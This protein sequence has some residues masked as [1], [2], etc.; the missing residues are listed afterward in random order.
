MNTSVSFLS[1]GGTP[2][3]L[4][5]SFLVLAAL[6][7]FA[8]KGAI[9]DDSLVV[10]LIL[11]SVLVHELCH[12]L[13]A[14]LFG[15][16][17]VDVV[18]Y[19]MGGV[20]KLDKKPTA[21]HEICIGLAGPACN[22]A[23]AG[24]LL[25]FQ[26]INGPNAVIAELL[27]AN[28]WIGAFNLLPAFPLDGGRVFRAALSFGFT[29]R[30]NSR[31]GIFVGRSVAAMIGLYGIWGQQWALPFVAFFIYTSAQKEFYSQKSSILMKGANV[32]E[33]MMRNFVTLQHGTS[34][35]EAA[36]L[37]LDSPQQDFPVM[38][39]TQVVG[40]LS[41]DELVDA[42]ANQGPQS[43]VA[44][45]M[46]RDFLRL[47]PVASIEESIRRLEENEYRALVMEEDRLLGIVT[48]DKL[49]EFLVLRQIGW[50]RALHEQ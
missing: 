14:R 2:V 32:K 22:F 48:Q 45:A 16:G 30:Q 37:L 4:H 18:I 25:L 15:V 9:V 5:F 42:L 41:R 10:I 46:D 40:L 12:G 35:S 17:T 29:D 13:V 27:R 38:H 3:R 21:T 33:A 39:G 43:F 34:I 47:S 11:F 20:A 50:R 44:S 31:I 19:F 26:Q 36:S 24:A 23:I 8:S 6:L 49:N 28:L 7:A 1:V